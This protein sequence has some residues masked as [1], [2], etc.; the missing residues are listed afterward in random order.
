MVDKSKWHFM[1]VPLETIEKAMEEANE[2]LRNY[3]NGEVTNTKAILKV[4]QSYLSDKEIEES[5][6]WLRYYLYALCTGLIP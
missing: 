3:I 5:G 2:N 6:E 1:G 4:R